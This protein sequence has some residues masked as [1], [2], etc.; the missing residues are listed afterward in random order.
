MGNCF[1]FRGHKNN[2]KNVPRGVNMTQREDMDVEHATVVADVSKLR[3]ILLEAK[4]TGKRTALCH[5]CF[6]GLHHGHIE[7]FTKAKDVADVVIVGVEGDEYI[8]RV[9]GEGR[10]YHVL[11]DRIEAIVKTNLVQYVIAIEPGDGGIY[12]KLYVYLSP[13]F[14]LTAEDEILM[15]KTRDAEEANVKVVVIEKTCSSNSM[16]GRS[17][18]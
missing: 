8:H 7:L 18:F 3:Q 11:K 15:K 2:I 13:D 14:L 5:G 12:R 1:S 6:D 16:K 4:R 10:P 17:L 9:K